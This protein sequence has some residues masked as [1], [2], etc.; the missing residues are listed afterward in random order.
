MNL[1]K[2]RINIL[3]ESKPFVQKYGWNENLLLN[4]FKNSKL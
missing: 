1:E 3:K 2:I 4:I